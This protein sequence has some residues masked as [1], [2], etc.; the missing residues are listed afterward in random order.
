MGGF[1][2]TIL[3]SHRRD[4]R[5]MRHHDRRWLV[6]ARNSTSRELIREGTV[7]FQG[8]HR[9][10]AAA[11]AADAGQVRL[12][13]FQVQRAAF[14]YEMDGCTIQECAVQPMQESNFLNKMSQKKDANHT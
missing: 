7:P 6:Q 4:Q 5:S 14:K 13:G 8:E 12:R 11:A 2:T 9:F 10:L 1:G 3:T